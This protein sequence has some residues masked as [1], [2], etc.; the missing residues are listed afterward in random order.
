MRV[1]AW[2]LVS[3]IAVFAASV[4]YAQRQRVVVLD[5][6]LPKPWVES[7]VWE[8]SALHGL[9]FL[10]TRYK[11]DPLKGNAMSWSNKE[12][13]LYAIRGSKLHKQMKR[14][15]PVHYLHGKADGIYYGGIA[16]LSREI[17]TG[18]A[19]PIRANGSDGSALAVTVIAHEVGHNRC[20]SHVNSQTLMNTLALGFAQQPRA[21]DDRSIREMLSCYK[22][23]KVC[24][25]QAR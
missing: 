14:Y 20:A 9:Q 8:A 12:A 2:L 16:L 5:P 10:P 4:A 22:V 7:L 17:S 6:S 19:G 18:Y 25:L 21:W 3:A 15:G 13:R 11:R 24:K 1:A 23:K